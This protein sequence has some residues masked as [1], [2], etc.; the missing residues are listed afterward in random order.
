MV[1][2]VPWNPAWA[3]AV[4]RNTDDGPNGTLLPDRIDIIV[5]CKTDT[6]KVLLHHQHYLDYNMLCYMYVI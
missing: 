4:L 1:P 2:W 3:G 6:D 5:S